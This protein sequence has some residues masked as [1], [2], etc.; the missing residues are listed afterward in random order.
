MS[1]SEMITGSAV[2]AVISDALL[3]DTPIIE[4]NEA[5]VSLT[6]F[7]REEI[8]GRN[9]RFLAGPETEPELTE[10]IRTA[11]RERRTVLVEILNYKKD[12]SPFRN[13]VMVAPLFD[14]KGELRYF[15][16]SQVEVS[17]PE[18]VRV[19]PARD[20][21]EKLTPRQKEVLLGLAAGRLNKEIAHDIGITERTVKMHRAALFRQLDC[22]TGADAI[23]IAIEAGF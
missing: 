7:S 9:C 3:P 16:G 5:F 8:L 10:E 22:R 4:C 18:P 17:S 11:V 12:G 15:L 14:D 23:R 1:P 21:I 20:R 13:A 19:S 6:G 2:A